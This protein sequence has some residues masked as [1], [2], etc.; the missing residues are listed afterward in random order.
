MSGAVPGRAATSRAPS[1]ARPQESEQHPATTASVLVE[2]GGG[3]GALV[4]YLDDSFRDREIEISR[5]GSAQ[6]VH[7]GVLDQHT[8]AGSVLAA[9]FGSLEAGRYVVWRDAE[10]PAAAVVVTDG[11]ITEWTSDPLE[12]GGRLSVA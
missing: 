6:R 12:E 10:T 11:S 4:L 9:V 1:P 2:V 7:T 5:A 3:K 8:A